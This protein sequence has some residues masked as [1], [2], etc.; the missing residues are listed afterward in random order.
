MFDNIYS[1]EQCL[2]PYTPVKQSNH[3]IKIIK[4]NGNCLILF[5]DGTVQ[6]YKKHQE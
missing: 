5:S 4:T 6:K 2:N 3:Q 1:R